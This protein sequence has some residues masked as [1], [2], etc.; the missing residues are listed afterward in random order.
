[1]HILTRPTVTQSD[2]SNGKHEPVTFNE[3]EFTIPQAAEFLRMSEPYFL[4]LLGEGKIPFQHDGSRRLLLVSELTSYR[5]KAEEERH[6]GL[7]ELGAL[8]QSMGLYD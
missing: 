7:D 3:S 2:L 4:K 5:T 8:S 1:M 6:R